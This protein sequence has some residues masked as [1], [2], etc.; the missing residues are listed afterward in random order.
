MFVA[1]VLGMVSCQNYL[2]DFD[3][4]IGG[5]QEVIV[6][7]SLPEETRAN[8]AEG[9]ISN[10]IASDEYTVRYIFQVYNAD[11]SQSKEAV[12]QY[13][14]DKSVSFP[15]RLVPNRD[16]RFVVW[17]DIVKESD[18]ADLHYNTSS[19]PE[20]S[21]KDTWVAMDETRDAYTVSEVVKEFN[22]AK[23]ISLTLKRPL[24]KL[25]VITTDMAELLGLTPKTATV[26]YVTEHYNTFNAFNSEVGDSK[27]GG[28]K[29]ENYAIKEYE[30]TNGKVLFTDY[31][32]AKDDVVKFNMS[33]VMSDDKSVD[34][35]FNTDIPVKRNHLTTLIGDILTEGNNI[36][37]NV[38]EGFENGTEWNPSDDKYDVEIWDGKSAQEPDKDSEGNYIIKL[39]SELA[40][41]ADQ[42]NG[43]TRAAAKTFQGETFK[44]TQ[45]IDLGFN[46]WTPI[47]NKDNKF[48][49]T[50]DG[51]GHKIANLLITGNNNYVGLFGF[52]TDGEIKDF[53]VE[54]AKVSGRLGVGVIAGS[55]YTS[56]FNDITIQGHVEVN[57]KFYVGGVAGYSAYASWNNIT[58]N[59]DET[60]YVNANSVEGDVAYRT[61]VGGVCGFNGEGGHSFTNI[62][63]N[64]DVKGS[65]I[66]AGGLFGIAHYGNQFENCSC[67]G[68]VEIYAAQEAV[69]AQE[70]GGIAGVWNNG[71]ADVV[72][73]NC[74]FTGTLKTNIAVDFYYDGLIG[75]PYSATGTGKL[76]IDGYEMIANGVGMK[77]GEYYIQSVAGLKWLAEQVNGGNNFSN[78]VVKLAADLDLNNEEWTPIGLTEAKSFRGAFDGQ[79]KT[80][81]NL[82]IDSESRAGLFGYV[83]RDSGSNDG[84]V[85][86]AIR[87]L[88]LHN[89]N[90][91]TSSGAALCGN[92]F[93]G[94]ISDI[95]L[96]GKVTIEGTNQNVAGVVGYHYGNLANITV[97][98]TEDSYVKSAT[99]YCGGVASYSGEG[100]YTKTNIESNIKVIASGE[101]VGGLF[102]LLQYG[103]SATD[104]SCS[105]TVIN[106]CAVDSHNR[107][108]RTGG[109]AGCWVENTSAKTT[110]TGCEFT[111]TV[112]ATRQDGLTAS[113]L[114]HG[115]LVG[116]SYSTAGYGELNID[117]KKYVDVYKSAGLANAVKLE[118]YTIYMTA[119]PWGDGVN[120]TEYTMPTSIADNV[121]IEGV[122]E[123]ILNM[124]N[125]SEISGADN[126]T[127]DGITVNWNGNT[128][129]GFT[130]STGHVYKNIT[131]NGAFFCWNQSARFEDC[132]FNLNA[133]QYI[134]TYGCNVDFERCTFNCVDGKGILIYNEGTDV[135]VNI[136]NC[137]FSSSKHAQTGNGQNIAAIEISN[138]V[139]NPK[140][141]VS[142]NNCVSHGG[143]AYDDFICRFKDEVTAENLANLNVTVD[144]YVMFPGRKV[145]AETGLY[146]NGETKPHKQ[147]FYVHNAEELAKATTYFAGQN[148]SNE[149]NTVTIDLVNDID[150][151]GVEW[152]PWSVMFITVNGNNHTISN[153]S[154]SFFGYAGAVTVNDLTLENVTAS[155]NQAGTFVASA[156]G[157]KFFNCFL[158]GNNK[159]TFVDDAKVENGVG[160]ISGITI[161]SNLN[162]TITEGTNVEVDM[163]TISNTEKTTF[164]NILTGYKH[165]VYAT[166]SGTITNN[167]NVSVKVAEEIVANSKGTGYS[168]ELFEEGAT[169]FFVLQNSTLT[170][171]AKITIK[172]T[173]NTVALE[174]VT[175]DI[176]DNLIVAEVD[177]TI[178][179]HNCDITLAEGKK[180]I[181]TVGGATI[182][183]VMIHN[184][185][186]NGETLT[187]QSAANFMEG[188]NWY[189]VW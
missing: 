113:K 136:N 9:G 92:L 183:Q 62:T 90:M 124:N 172:R 187:Q 81:Y 32:F 71:G 93:R 148:H 3:V 154:N 88:K 169:D 133:N 147:R 17:A 55:P 189:E 27:V 19:F 165:T 95:E 59:V 181:V 174:G 178:I 166:N 168:G 176:N 1:L 146:W 43:V 10:V 14:D 171:D 118:G 105:A 122:K 173:Y 91:K 101:A 116:A 188:V 46:E 83:G 138:A 45:D 65:T 75:K 63:S 67:S 106:D 26:S 77:D 24:A 18:K 170:D 44:L 68:D 139:N 29:H 12:K 141:T 153:L 30:T 111:G 98:V 15:V 179:L 100:D 36:T 73:T 6:N 35:S 54:N 69:D 76:I 185:K 61:Y 134:W 38:E 60:S 130:H 144:G 4:N 162:V 121:T 129:S 86:G 39:P 25:R 128:Y 11:G 8:S 20:I 151:A 157:A 167:G 16:Y 180:L 155:G 56:K 119:G 177:N 149:A 85:Y 42:V 22:S 120:I 108:V 96:T 109:I 33:V 49:G 31:F 131:F 5:E 114:A 57:G 2:D 152:N 184:V 158:K 115:G 13:S 82:R 137:E 97:D 123:A 41:L 175:A 135:T 58:I 140:F 186:V 87:N 80:I 74:T 78:K 143:F 28:C 160:A 79:G 40:W 48:Q 145:H 164:D 72:F 7:V 110:L 70:I 99:G 156:E 132:T 125:I 103:N 161:N 52:T 23:S 112:K 182:G 126:L 104:C 66:D 117:G 51:Q 21:L 53:V 37:V 84:N 47:G 142:I 150:L 107:Y 94:E 159:V 102:A 34:R 64:I 50:F 89:V 163:N 127:I